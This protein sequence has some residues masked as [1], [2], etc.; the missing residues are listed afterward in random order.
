MYINIYTYIYRSWM[1]SDFKIFGSADLSN[2]WLDHL[3]DGDT[4]YSSENLIDILRTPA[5][6]CLICTGTPVKSLLENPGSHNYF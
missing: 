4:V 5:K 3:S 1:R 2:F 6:K